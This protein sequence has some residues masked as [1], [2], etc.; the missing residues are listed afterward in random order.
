M[1]FQVTG[2]QTP[3]FGE[4]LPMEALENLHKTQDANIKEN[5]GA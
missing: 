3:N 1:A 2:I 5:R 4:T